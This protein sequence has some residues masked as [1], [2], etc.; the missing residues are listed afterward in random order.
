MVLLSVIIIQINSLGCSEMK[1]VWMYIALT[2]YLVSPDT[3]V[4]LWVDRSAE[5][6]FLTFL[7]FDAIAAGLP[8]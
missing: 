1:I 7:E 4:G 6:S 2:L 8:L 3:E 5:K